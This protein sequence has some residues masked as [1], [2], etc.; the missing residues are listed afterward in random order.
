[1][2]VGFEDKHTRALFDGRSTGR[3]SAEVE[4]AAL[5]KLQ[6]LHA[7]T[8]ITSLQAVPGLHCKKMSGNLKA[9]W[10]IR[11]N[12]RFRILFAWSEPPP[13][14]SQACLCDPH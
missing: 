2:I 12:D 7:A 4:R 8:S 10:S 9:F 5:R 13:E 14:T 6:V 3:F 1:M 11:V